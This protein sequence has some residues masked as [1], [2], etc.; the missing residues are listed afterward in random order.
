[1]S[2]PIS[3]ETRVIEWTDSLIPAIDEV[4]PTLSLTTS[5]LLQITAVEGHGVALTPF[6]SDLLL[7]T[8][9]ECLETERSI[10]SGPY[11]NAPALMLAVADG[12]YAIA[13]V[14]VAAG[15][16][17]EEI[18]TT[19]RG[20]ASS[21]VELARKLAQQA[22]KDS[23]TRAVEEFSRIVA[24]LSGRSHHEQEAEGGLA[25]GSDDSR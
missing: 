3:C 2:L 10:N 15:A 11:S 16:D 13:E 14:L 22:K 12:N 5:H 7:R 6:A 4:V 8:A 20:S 24:L 21:P 17:P 23:N 1:M 9:K 19:P 25:K 18:Y